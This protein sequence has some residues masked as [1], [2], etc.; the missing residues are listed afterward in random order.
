MGG[1]VEFR[2]AGDKYYFCYENGALVEVGSLDEV[3][4]FI[5][6]I[7]AGLFE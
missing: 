6:E 5:K 3:V 2:N 7:T 1:A 4:A